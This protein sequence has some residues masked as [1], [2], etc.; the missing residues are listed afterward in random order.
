VS[1]EPKPTFRLCVRSSKAEG[2]FDDAGYPPVATLPEARR[3]AWVHA[4]RNCVD[5]LI[6]W[7]SRFQIG[8]WNWNF[9]EVVEYATVL[10]FAVG[11][12]QHAEPVVLMMD[13][14]PTHWNGDRLEPGQPP[15]RDRPRPEGQ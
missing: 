7:D 13:I 9:V 3:L 15:P 4:L 11:A 6:D 2:R 12:I 1:T 8:R 5:V 10:A 14:R